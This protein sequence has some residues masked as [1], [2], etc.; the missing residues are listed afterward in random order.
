MW[1]SMAALLT[2]GSL[3]FAP[4]TPAVHLE[5]GNWNPQ[6]RNRLESLLQSHRQEHRKVVFD[7][8]NTTLVRDIGDATFAALL[9]AKKIPITPAIRAISPAFALDGK[10]V[11]LDNSLD[12]AD[13]YEKL[14]SV[15]QHAADDSGAANAYAWVT[16]IMEGLSPAE[17]IA[18]SQKAYQDNQASQ[19]RQSG[20]ETRLWVTPGQTSY[21]VPFFTDEIIDLVGQLLLNGYDLYFVSGSNA[22]TIRYM[23]TV[24][25]M[26]R[27]NAR[28]QT[29]FAIPSEHVFG[30]TTLL[31]DR[32]SG[33]LL[34]DA[35]LVREQTPQARKYAALDPQE[36]ANYTL[37][38]QVVNPVTGFEGKTATI[39]QFITGPREHPFLV[40]GDSSGDF[41]MLGYA[42]N[43]LWFAR[44]ENRGYQATLSSRIPDT[45]REHWFVQP[46]LTKLRPGLVRD[47]TQLRQLLPDQAPELT[48]SLKI[49]SSR[50][51]YRD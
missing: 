15:P 47:Q 40:A 16:Q 27:V 28:F 38:N 10:Q 42:E 18:A 13:Y 32:R 33:Q 6:T 22:W 19:D 21:R 51:M 31:R 30:V 45:D 35:Y 12:L 41:S 23:V 1:M 50:G 7:F 17:I 37:T 14:S 2:A 39:I 36:L 5:A 49:W 46:S 20:Q 44:L 34:K 9:Q 48:D 26:K 25:L 29:H 11:T 3:F 24:E 43:R 8:D 4:L